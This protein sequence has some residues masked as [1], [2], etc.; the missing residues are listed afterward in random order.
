[1]ADVLENFRSKQKN[2]VGL[3]FSTIAGF[4]PHGA[5]PHYQATKFTSSL[6]YDNSTL[7]LDSG[8]QYYGNFFFFYDEHLNREFL[9]GTIDVTRT[10]HLGIP[11]EE[12]KEAYTRV[13]MGSIQLSSL[14]FPDKLSSGNMDALA[15][16]ALWNIGYDY[17]H[18]TGHG[19]GVFSNVHEGL[20]YIFLVFHIS[21][22]KKFY[23]TH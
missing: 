15:R 8:G 16:S 7:V 4:G 20:S 2:F 6:L 9:D 19:I 17:S 21:Y 1:M 11:T 3:S 18:G 22:N 23:S 14:T 12:H 5:L 10:L 13:L